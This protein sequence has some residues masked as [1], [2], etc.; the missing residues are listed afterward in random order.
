MRRILSAPKSR[1]RWFTSFK[2]AR[3][4]AILLSFS[5]SSFPDS[6]F[7]FFSI[8]DSWSTD[9]QYTS[10]VTE[11]MSIKCFSRNFG[12]G[13]QHV[14]RS[15][16]YLKSSSSL[17]AGNLQIARSTCRVQ[18]SVLKALRTTQNPHAVPRREFKKRILPRAQCHVCT[19]LLFLLFSVALHLL[20]GL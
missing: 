15:R 6:F 2:A 9:I 14:L 12:V 7:S 8:S 10:K 5:F 17:A 4:C 3:T 11:L 18:K 1:F 13:I 20:P 16:Q 19:L